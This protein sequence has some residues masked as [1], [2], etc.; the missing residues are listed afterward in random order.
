MCN[1]YFN[2]GG[3]SLFFSKLKFW[4]KQRFFDMIGITNVKKSGGEFQGLKFTA[5]EAGA[6]I[7]YK[8]YSLSLTPD[9]KYSYDGIT[10]YNWAPNTELTLTDI[11]NYIYVKGNNPNGFGT[12][13]D[14][15][16]SQHCLSFV[17]NNGDISAS[18]NI[19]SLLDNSNGNSVKTLPVD[20]CYIHLFEDC[21]DLISAPQLTALT[22]TQGCYSY[23]FAGCTA[24]TTA[25]DI[26]ATN[27]AASCCAEMFEGC[28][29]LTSAPVLPA[30]VLKRYCYYRM[31][32]GCTSLTTAPEIDALILDEGCFNSMFENCTS[33]NN[34]KLWYTGDFEFECFENWVDGIASS[35]TLYYDGYDTTEGVSAIPSGWNVSTGL[36]ALRLTSN[37]NISSVSYLVSNESLNP[38]IKYSYDG[39]TWETLSPGT[40]INLGQNKYI[41]LKGNNT[42]GIST[43]SSNYMHFN[44][45][46]QVLAS[47]NVNSLLDNADGNTITTIPTYC[48]YKL[49]IG[50]NALLSAPLLPA[51]TVGSSCYRGMFKDCTNLISVPKLPATNLGAYCYLSMFNGCSS[52]IT[53][54]ELPAI[55][56]SQNCYQSMY[57]NCTSLT[58]VK[59]L[60]ATTLAASCYREMFKGCT[61]LVTIPKS[62]PAYTLPASCYNSMFYGCSSL[63]SSPTLYGTTLNSS[64]YTNLFYNCESLNKITIVYTGNFEST[65]F[66]N[67]VANVAPSGD[68]YYNGTDINNIGVSAIPTGWTIHN[69]ENT[70]VYE[71]STIKSSQY[72]NPVTSIEQ[73]IIEFTGLYKITLK[74]QQGTNKDDTE[75]F[76]KGG[77]LVVTK[78][79]N[80]GDILSFRKING[81]YTTLPVDRYWYGGC[82]VALFLVENGQASVELVAGGGGAYYTLNSVG[83]TTYGG[84]GGGGFT[85]GYSSEG[86]SLKGYSSDGTR[87]NSTSENV[88]PGGGK[89]T[90]GGFGGTGYIKSGYTVGLSNYANNEGNGYIKLEFLHY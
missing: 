60:P 29:S 7:S 14:Y 65:Y 18:G 50:C 63:K 77:S 15:G 49:F 61:S 55:I 66:N 36:Q 64:C 69:T 52:I 81:A 27:L 8:T 82:G 28:T 42:S 79:F 11:G 30:L 75:K 32:N 85:G 70:T 20:W 59:T 83:S 9:I 51:N 21:T 22:L 19:N 17:I 47:G 71:N 43:S 72:S 80:E 56:L 26:R 87:G 44:L 5:A 12:D 67:W 35:G 37:Q 16:P 45:T 34:I 48:Y 57:M 62:L 1:K 76:A 33:L 78:R 58:E 40:V 6:K 90:Y 86:D 54:Q 53:T 24:L 4:I 23:M 89:S 3:I 46:G 41:Y 74:G 39:T 2:Y 13:H 68:F 88:A 25:P 10:W 84:I 31:F 38:D 73:K